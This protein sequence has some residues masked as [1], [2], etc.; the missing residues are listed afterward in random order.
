MSNLQDLLGD[1][2]NE[3]DNPSTDYPSWLNAE[4]R[5]L[6]EAIQKWDGKLPNTLVT[7]GKANPV[8]AATGQN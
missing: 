7:D 3:R 2:Q 5:A 1:E 8:L 6:Y 4:G